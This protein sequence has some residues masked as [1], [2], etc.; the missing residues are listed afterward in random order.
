MVCGEKGPLE[1]PGNRPWTKK[2]N[3][4]NR[5]DVKGQKMEKPLAPKPA[6][7]AKKKVTRLE[8]FAV[9]NPLSRRFPM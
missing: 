3:R 8:S 6:L 1:N 7:N 4:R 5:F 2:P 9:N